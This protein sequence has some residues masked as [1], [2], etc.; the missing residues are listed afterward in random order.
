MVRLSKQ[1]RKR[2]ITKKRPRI[3]GEKSSGSG[4]RVARPTF[5]NSLP[6]DQAHVAFIPMIS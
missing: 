2:H 3:A 4:T 6:K 5:V 1:A